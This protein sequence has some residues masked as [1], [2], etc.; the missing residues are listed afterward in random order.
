MDHDG[1]LDEGWIAQ[2]YEVDAEPPARRER[3]PRDQARWAMAL[4]VLGV[5]CL[6][7]VFGPM[8]LSRGRRVALSLADAPELGGAS[9]AEA[10]MMV[11]K[12]GLALHLAIAATLIPWLLFMLPFLRG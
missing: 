2:A 7:F 12:A 11:G 10:A 6:G 5:L 1:S 8:A 4:A 3:P 9:T